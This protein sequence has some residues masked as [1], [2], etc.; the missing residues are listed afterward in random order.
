MVFVQVQNVASF[1]V[2]DIHTVYL[3]CI[4]KITIFFYQES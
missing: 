3:L 2:K 1:S 4:L